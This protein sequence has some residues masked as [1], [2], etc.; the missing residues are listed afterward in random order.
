MKN[1]FLR[2]QSK[3]ANKKLIHLE[4]TMFLKLRMM[5]SNS[6]LINKQSSSH[7]SIRTEK[8]YLP[9]GRS[10]FTLKCQIA[11][12]RRRSSFF[13]ERKSYKRRIAGSQ[14]YITQTK[15]N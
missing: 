9:L 13:N 4:K 12:W 7:L 3:K 11:S 5:K 2:K 10:A 6:S 15:P 1:L 14:V 8:L